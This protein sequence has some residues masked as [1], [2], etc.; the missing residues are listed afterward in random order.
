VCALWRYPVK[1]L[2]GESLREA[3]IA[4]NGLRGD[5]A[6][7]IRELDRGG[8]M[9][10]RTWPAMLRLSAGYEGGLQAD[11]NARVRIELPGIHSVYADDR[12]ASAMLSEL[13]RRKVRLERTR[14]ERLTPE[15][16]EAIMRGEAYPPRRDFFDEDVIH[17]IASGTL[18]H[19]R[20]LCAGSDFDPRRFRANI[21][22]DTGAE[23]DGFIED[24]WLEGK[25]VIGENVGITGM[26]PA[27]RCAMTTH[28]QSELPHDVAILRTAWQHHQAYV[29][30][31][32]AVGAPG[33]IRVGDPV[34]LVTGE[35]LQR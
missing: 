30:V 22:V 20:T 10:A 28:P 3:D 27:I 1:S 35:E 19:L 24:R 33:R 32:A 16:L 23:N 34:T 26:R 21:Y 14:N 5:R 13:F 4:D 6:W 9:S 18:E 29:G 31:F 2:R 11:D 17:I 12:E 8:I 15:E 25:L 7:A